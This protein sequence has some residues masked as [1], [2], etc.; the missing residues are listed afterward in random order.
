M[1]D[2]DAL[3]NS[4]MKSKKTDQGF[5]QTQ[6]KFS[7]GMKPAADGVVPGANG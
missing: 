6:S 3:L 4:T 5:R 2:P 7:S 1:T